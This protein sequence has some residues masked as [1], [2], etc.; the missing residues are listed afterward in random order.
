MKAHFTSGLEILKG[1]VSS[2]HRATSGS[3]LMLPPKYQTRRTS[4][5]A[6]GN[7]GL[8]D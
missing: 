1:F 5:N 6:A 4:A 3:V 8:R 2:S 7:Q